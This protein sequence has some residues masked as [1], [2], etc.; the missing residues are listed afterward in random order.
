MSI[1]LLTENSTDDE[2]DFVE[3]VSRF[4][5]AHKQAR[6]VTH[7]GITSLAI[8]AT[9]QMTTSN[10][11]HEAQPFCIRFMDQNMYDC[12]D[13]TYDG[14]RSSVDRRRAE[15]AEEDEASAHVGR[16]ASEQKDPRKTLAVRW[17][18]SEPHTWAV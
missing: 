5:F 12:R 7:I 13:E 2:S 11:T 8:Q 9:P 17:C 10:P 1:K 6:D 14:V 4:S 15:D 3:A 16:E 18:W